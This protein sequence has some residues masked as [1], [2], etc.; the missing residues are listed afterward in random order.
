MLI[1]LV[2]ASWFTDLPASHV[3]SVVFPHTAE[4][5]S[6]SFHC[7][8][9]DHFVVSPSY[10][11]VH[12]QPRRH[13][14]QRSERFG[15]AFH[16]LV[17]SRCTFVASSDSD[18]PSFLSSLEFPSITRFPLVS[19]PASSY[20]VTFDHFGSYFYRPLI[21][22]NH[23]TIGVGELRP[24]PTA[25]RPFSNDPCVSNLQ[26]LHRVENPDGR[27]PNNTAQPPYSKSLRSGWLVTGSYLP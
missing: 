6:V 24:P 21:A 16:L 18:F 5:A 9:A 12:S 14:R 23:S 3:R 26:E 10:F 20:L 11:S 2:E 25:F 1:L 4:S 19:L 22:D 17:L 27:P 13:H 8:A 7:G 15:S